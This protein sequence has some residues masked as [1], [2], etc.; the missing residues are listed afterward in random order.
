MSSEPELFVIDRIESGVAVLVGDDGA[1][2]DIPLAKL[3]RG[4][5]RGTVLRAPRDAT[6]LVQWSEAQIDEEETER[7]LAEAKAVLDELRQRDPGGDIIL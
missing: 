7:R 3:P 5:R 6:G 4:A 2:L 1:V